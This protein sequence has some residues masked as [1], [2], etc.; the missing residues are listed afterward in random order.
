MDGY[1]W[2]YDN[3]NPDYWYGYE[4][5][6]HILKEEFIYGG[7]LTVDLYVSCKVSK[8]VSF[9]WGV[10]NVFNVHPDFAAVKNARYEA[11]DNESGGAWEPVQMGYNGRRLFG[12]VAFT[13]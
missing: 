6:K 4:D 2:Q 3:T 7:K 12:K 9:F 5:S 8:K 11:F 10:D 1:D 13:F